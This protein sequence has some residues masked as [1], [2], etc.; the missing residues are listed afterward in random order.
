MAFWMYLERCERDCIAPRLHSTTH[1]FSR[2]ALSMTKDEGCAIYA[3]ARCSLF[4][5][6]GEG[7]FHHHHIYLP[8][9]KINFKDIYSMLLGEE[10]SGNHQAYRRGHLDITI[11]NEIRAA[12]ECGRN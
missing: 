8:Y 6:W 5:D 3:V 7:I 4:D 2:R 11:L 1:K 10:T 12:K 9:C